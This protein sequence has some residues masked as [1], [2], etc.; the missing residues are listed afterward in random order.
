MN[1]AVGVRSDVGRVREGNEDSYLA[2]PPLFVIA[3]G[4]GGHSAGEV[5]SETAVK[6][7]S[8]GAAQISSED[9]RSL[10]RLL[11]N[12]NAAIFTKA[13]SDAALRGMGTT[14]T[15][16][17]AGESSA[18]IAHV[19]DSRAYRLRDGAIEQLTDDH[20]L[21][22]R[23]VREGQISLE[24]AQHHPQRNVITNAL[25]L[26]SNIVVDLREIE[27]RAGDRLMLCSDG[28]SSMVSDEDIAAAANA[29][30]DPQEAAETLVELALE[31]GGED[32]I[33]VL[34]IDLGDEDK[35]A[36]AATPLRTETSPGSSSPAPST[37]H[38][39]GRKW[40]GA[41]LLVVLVL[42]A[43]YGA[44]NWALDNSYYVGVDGSGRV[45]IYQGI[46][47]RI[48]GLTLAEA[49]EP[50]ALLLEDLPQSRHALLRQGMKV[51]SLGEAQSTVSDLSDLARDFKRS[52]GDSKA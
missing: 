6:V 12:A 36:P 30:E 21:V 15:L 4:M 5:A 20:T 26:D 8:D 17:M 45:T 16:L 34:V 44:G 46:P 48:A 50:S 10:A 32:N 25:G 2:E 38:S 13:Q 19:G 9:P 18:H 29:A 22:G 40:L 35:P 24:E 11:N 37:S 49:I 3:D 31:A 47:E 52:R 41:L 43:A 23:M 7:I 51:E 28:L 39:G 33:T 27:A 1:T 42:A 14:C